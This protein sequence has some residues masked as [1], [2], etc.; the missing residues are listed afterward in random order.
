MASM[1]LSALASA[2]PESPTLKLNEEAARLRESGEPVIH[3]GGG[4][5]KNRT[6]LKAVEACAAKLQA[7]DI[8]YTPTGGLLSLK[9]AV[10]EYTGRNYG[11]TVSPANVIICAGAKHALYNLLFSILNPGDEVIILAPYWV[12][13]P[14]MVRMCQGVPVIVRP[15]GESLLPDMKDILKAVSPRTKAVIVNSPNNPSGVLYPED[16]VAALVELCETR[17]VTLISDDIYHK[18][19]FGGK[20]PA[21]PYRFTQKDIEST[22]IV[23]VNGVSKVFGMTG[24]R[25]G[26][27]VAPKELVRVMSN[28]QAQSV[29][30][31]SGLLQAG[32]EGALRGAMQDVGALVAEL[33]SGCAAMIQALG[34]LKDV[35]VRPPDGTFYC[36]PDFSAYN[37][38]S[39]A[40]SRF[41]LEKALVVTVP[42]KEFGMEGHLRL[43]Y[44]TGV[45]NVTEGVARIRW[46]LDPSAPKEILLGGKKAVRDW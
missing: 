10:I 17:G 1:T 41:L 30:C 33:E 45:G 15:A 31:V 19:V 3:L 43:S 23:A 5:P 35:K 6:P 7:G 34:A 37:K 24:F 42:G 9:K 25:I 28:V 16:L 39:V 36:L 40:L 26:W 8:K 14:D 22:R 44:C 2:V 32:A 20:V 38:D 27:A 21:S 4:E 13:Y 46:A 18:L 12:S 11:R 29:S